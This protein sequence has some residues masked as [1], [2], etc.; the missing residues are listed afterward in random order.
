VTTEISVT[1]QG[2]DQGCPTTGFLDFHVASRQHQGELVPG[3]G[4]EYGRDTGLRASRRSRESAAG[5]LD[6]RRPARVWNPGRLSGDQQGATPRRKPRC[7]KRSLSRGGRP[8][9][10]RYE[11]QGVHRAHAVAMS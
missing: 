7:S 8:W 11:A 5:A 9:Q 6:L 2:I 4:F 3:N 1:F 10:S